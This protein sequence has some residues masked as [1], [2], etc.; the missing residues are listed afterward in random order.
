MHHGGTGCNR[1]MRCDLHGGLAVSAGEM[2][3]MKTRLCRLR[4]YSCGVW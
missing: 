2:R 3:G 1:M 4:T